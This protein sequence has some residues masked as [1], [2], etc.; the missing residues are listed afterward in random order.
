MVE[1]GDERFR[2]SVNA[3]RCLAR[4]SAWTSGG[5]ERG[6]FRSVLRTIALDFGTK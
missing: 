1:S 2:A 5:L 6:R 4:L 3:W